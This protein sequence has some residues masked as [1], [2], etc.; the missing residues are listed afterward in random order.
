MK[1]VVCG[2][3]FSLQFLD[4]SYFVIAGLDWITKLAASRT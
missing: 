4:A 3:N 2:S 1:E